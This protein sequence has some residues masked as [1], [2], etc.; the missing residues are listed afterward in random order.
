[1]SVK[2]ILLTAAAAAITTIATP[3]S[4]QFFF[5]PPVLK[6]G[7][8][9]GDEAG[10]GMAL[11]GASELE[12]KA[13]LVWSLRAALNVAALQCQFEPLLLTVPNYNAVLTDHQKELSSSYDVLGKYFARN[14]KTKKAGM[15][16][17][18]KFGTRIYSS[19]SAVS[20]QYTFCQ[21]ASDVGADAVFTPR[22]SFAD[23]AQR[24][25]R[26]LRN[27][28]ILSGEQRFAGRIAPLIGT[29]RMPRADKNCWKSDVYQPAK[30]GAWY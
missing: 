20:S 29:P 14:A 17:L 18:D 1:M 13:A 9:R 15:D 28:L 6:S 25:M 16:A 26:E 27:S 2:R 4:A 24:R 7:P 12:Q 21:A 19:F 23:V 10:L 5:Q 22:G 30:C 3:A 8:V 11:T